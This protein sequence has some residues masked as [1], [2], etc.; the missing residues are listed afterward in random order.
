MTNSA[1]V[2]LIDPLLYQSTYINPNPVK[3]LKINFWKKFNFLNFIINIGIPLSILVFVLFVLKDKY[4]SKLRKSANIKRI[5]S[6]D[7][8]KENY[9]IPMMTYNFQ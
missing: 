3:P 4:L 7:L 8:M 2:S 5:Q 1:R 6:P 9:K